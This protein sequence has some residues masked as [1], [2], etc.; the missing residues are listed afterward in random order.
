MPHT[1][2]AIRNSEDAFTI[3]FT[4]NVSIAPVHFNQLLLIAFDNGDTHPDVGGTLLRV[5][6]FDLVGQ[7]CAAGRKANVTSLSSCLTEVEKIT[8]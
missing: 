8:V 2:K 6:L 4:G 3:A 7:R 1:S 5:P